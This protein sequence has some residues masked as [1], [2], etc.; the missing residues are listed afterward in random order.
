M[1]KTIFEMQRD[2]LSLVQRMLDP[3][4]LGFAV[5]AE[6]RDLAREV[7]GLERVESKNV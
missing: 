3:E 7:L 6:V 5:T 2:A 4:D 1:P